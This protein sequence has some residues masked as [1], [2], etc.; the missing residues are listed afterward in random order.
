[1][2]TL[3]FNELI[4]YVSNDLSLYLKSFIYESGILYN[5]R[6]AFWESNDMNAKNR[7]ITRML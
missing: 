7:M 1:M 3:A 4:M 2:L 6:K 5:V